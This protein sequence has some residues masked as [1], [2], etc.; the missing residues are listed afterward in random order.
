MANVEVGGS[1]EFSVPEPGQFFFP[2]FSVPVPVNS[3]LVYSRRFHLARNREILGSRQ[4]NI[5]LKNVLDYIA[6]DGAF[7][8]NG[9][10]QGRS[11][12]FSNGGRFPKF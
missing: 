4:L 11:Q 6:V 12:E 2:T 1:R 10:M 5:G 8:K 7:I 3:R 9:Y